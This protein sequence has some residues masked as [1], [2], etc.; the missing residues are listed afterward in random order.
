MFLELS[1]FYQNSAGPD[2]LMRVRVSPF[3]K[4]CWSLIQKQ[5]QSDN[6]LLIL[7]PKLSGKRNMP[8]T[9]KEICHHI[10]CQKNLMNRLC[11]IFIFL[12]FSAHKCPICSIWAKHN[13][14]L[15]NQ[16][17]VKY[18]MN[19]FQEMLK[20]WIWATEYPIYPILGTPRIFHNKLSPWL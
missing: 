6:G 19:K 8:K 5:T 15:N 16:A 13:F 4:V 11:K 14:L 2:V 17:V 1:M 7:T 18:L 3:E 20:C 12:P 10:K 9:F